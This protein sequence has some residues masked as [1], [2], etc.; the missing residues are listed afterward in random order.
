MLEKFFS[1]KDNNKFEI[2]NLPKLSNLAK[3]KYLDKMCASV[4]ISTTEFLTTY[5]PNSSKKDDR[6]IYSNFIIGAALMEFNHLYQAKKYNACLSLSKKIKEYYISN[7]FDLDTDFRRDIEEKFKKMNDFFTQ[8]S[9][10]DIDDD[11][12][13]EVQSDD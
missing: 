12:I 6:E 7:Y 11:D 8:L 9:Q 3:K 13:D 5:R 2:N 4:N 1:K 10:S